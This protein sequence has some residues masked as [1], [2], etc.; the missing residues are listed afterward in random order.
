MNENNVEN[1]DFRQINFSEKGISKGE[2]DSCKFINCDFSG[3]NLSNIAFID[4]KFENCNFSMA[5]IKGTAFKDAKFKN[6]KLLGLTFNECDPFLLL[7][8]FDTC[9]LNLSSFYKLVLKKIEF[10]NCTLHEVDFTETNLT[11][12]KFENCDLTRAIFV[13]TIL[14]KADFSTSYNYSFDPE[15][16]RIKKAKFSKMGVIGLLGK[17][18]III[19]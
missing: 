15:I 14:E 1:K 13:N 9:H 10:K 17:Y 19:E 6:C 11:N 18:D 2:Y 16:N 4:C 5:K 7:L 8:E 3:V 12:A